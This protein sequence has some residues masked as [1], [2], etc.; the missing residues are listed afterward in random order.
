MIAAISGAIGRRLAYG[1]FH[2]PRRS[3]HRVPAD[4]GLEAV[5]LG[6]ETSDGVTLHA[7]AIDGRGEGVVVIGHGIGL[8][9]SASLA[10][11]RLA[12]ELGYG[13]LLFDHRNH[14]LSGQDVASQDL[15]DRFSLDI[16]ATLDEATRRWPLASPRVVWGFSFSTFPTLYSLRNDDAPIDAVILDSGPGDDLTALLSEF[17]LRGGMPLPRPLA[18]MLR[19]PSVAAAFAGSAVAML[20]C[21][22]PPVLGRVVP[23][24]FIVGD[25]DTLVPPWQTAQLAERYPGSVV[26]R[27]PVTHLAG[28]K[29][30]QSEYAATVSEF[31]DTLEAQRTDDKG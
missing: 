28:I 31:L 2:P 11:A 16:A 17:L 29:A 23:M 7:W 9:K 27:L 6:I 1:L 3:H 22:W 24:Q 18:P 12:V 13:V 8:S 5:S 15:A 26:T 20:G 30:A 19:T 4:L 14:G 10:H 21:E 25:Q